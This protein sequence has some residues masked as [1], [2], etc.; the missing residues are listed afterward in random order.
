[1]SNEE[2]SKL[3]KGKWTPSTI[4]YYTPGIKSAHPSQWEDSI[5]LLDK[6]ISSGLTLDD[7]GTA[8]T[9]SE[10]I[11]SHG[12]NLDSVID[13]LFTADTSSLEI[14][15]LIHQYE[16]LRESSL[17]PENVSEA[18]S[19]KEELEKKGV[20]L[21]SLVPLVELAKKHGE[22]Q[23]I[24]QAL[25]KHESLS[26]L[27]EQVDSTRHELE[28]LDQQVQEVETKLTQLVKPIEAYEKAA[29]LG[30]TEQELNKL[31]GLV[32]K[33]G[34]INEVLKVVEAYTS[35]ADIASK[36]TKIKAELGEIQGKISKLETQ[37][38]HLKTATIMCDNL[39]Q[40]YKFGLDAITTIFSVAKNYGEPLDVLKSIEVYGKLQALQQELGKLKG[41]VAE[42]KELLAQLEGNNQE[43]LNHIESL[44]ARAM[45]VGAEVSKVEHKLQES[46][47]LLKIINL[48]NDPSSADYNEYG[49]LVVA[50]VKA[51]LQWV[52]TNEKYFPY[53]HGMKSA[54]QNL[55]K[56]LGG[57]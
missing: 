14:T 27:T 33:Y 38:A 11:K 9:V 49:P 8:V 56:D 15:A 35:H 17:S 48:I 51:V 16:L 53:P 12:I 18:L 29:K 47:A 19:L 39:I 44:N 42:C 13:L 57:D 28:S 45:T 43:A 20:G 22:P 4:K 52:S 32:E 24:I 25:S 7:V 23:Q 50:L 2:I 54:L 31:S 26:E 1:M 3:S 46:K 5:A 34:G 36:T 41:N 30:F 37:Y 55:L 6:L 40:Q 21:D 10:D